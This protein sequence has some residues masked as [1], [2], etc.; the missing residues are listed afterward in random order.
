MAHQTDLRIRL[1]KKKAQIK[2]ENNCTLN[3]PFNWVNSFEIN[4]RCIPSLMDILISK[5]YKLKKYIIPQKS[6]NFQKLTELSV[7]DPRNTLYYKK[8][9]PATTTFNI[10][11]PLQYNTTT[12]TFSHVNADDD[13]LGCDVLEIHAPEF[14][15]DL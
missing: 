10:N 7:D 3:N 13:L 4:S 9:S 15:P 5:P 2:R 11:I 1:L 12:T 8:S 6:I 14:D